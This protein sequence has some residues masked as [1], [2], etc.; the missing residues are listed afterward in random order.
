M[1]CL[2]D[3]TRQDNHCLLFARSHKN[4]KTTTLST[5][6]GSTKPLGLY[7]QPRRSRSR[8]SMLIAI[9]FSSL[10]NWRDSSRDLFPMFKRNIQKGNQLNLSQI[11]IW[12]KNHIHFYPQW[13]AAMPLHWNMHVAMQSS[14]QV[15]PLL[16]LTMRAFI[17]CFHIMQINHTYYCGKQEKP[18]DQ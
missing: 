18:H 2:D 6:C 16:T 13:Y 4:A 9:R 15:S 12:P 8:L 11:F 3:Y 14:F 5:G 1:F 10:S 17:D 7:G